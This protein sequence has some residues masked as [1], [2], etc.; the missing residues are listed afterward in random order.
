VALTA[1]ALIQAGH[2]ARQGRSALIKW[3]ADVAAVLDP[4]RPAGEVYGRDPV[5]LDEGFPLLP[6]AALALAPFLALGDV[7]GAVLFAA[8]KLALAWWMLASTL[9]L[10][11]PDWR[12]WPPWGVALVIALSVRVLLSDVSHGNVNIV[13]GATV[14]ASA[15][16][17]SRS[18]ARASLASRSL[19]RSISR[20]DSCSSSDAWVDWCA[21]IS[22]SY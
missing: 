16:A 3:R 15:V 13:V 10:A 7:P 12:G 19:F 5:T 11:G 18:E 6:V 21:A 4:A 20:P 8:C 22:V 1:L 9:R 17:W 2:R 14:V